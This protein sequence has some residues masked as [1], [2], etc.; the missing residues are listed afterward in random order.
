MGGLHR[1]I[2]ET[3]LRVD[4]RRTSANGPK[5]KKT[6]DNA[7]GLTHKRCQIDFKRQEKEEEQLS[8][9]KI[10]LMHRYNYE[11]TT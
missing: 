10:A 9:F 2:L 7:E 3:I 11:K 1:K 6:H 5:N 8:I 4:E